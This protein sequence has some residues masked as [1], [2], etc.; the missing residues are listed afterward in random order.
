MSPEGLLLRLLIG[1]LVYWLGEKVIA[2]VKNADLQAILNIIL[3]I[4]VVIYVLFGN[5]ITI[6]LR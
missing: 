6:T 2:L 3:I 4:F 5:A 1:V